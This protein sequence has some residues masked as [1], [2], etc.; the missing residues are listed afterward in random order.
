[1]KNIFVLLFILSTMV[2]AEE[3]LLTI[4]KEHHGHHGH[5]HQAHSQSPIGVMGAHL[6]DEGQWMF[7][8]RFKYMDMEGLRD[9][10]K[11]VSHLDNVGNP[12]AQPGR[13]MV[14]PRR[15]RMKMHMLSAMYG[16]TDKWTI[17]LMVPW[18]EK[19]M[20]H[21]A[22]PGNHFTTR[23]DGFGDIKVNSLYKLFGSEEFDLIFNLGVSL[24]TGNID[25][26]G[27]TPLAPNGV[28]LP[29][30]MQLGSGTLDISPGLTLVGH[31]ENW[32]WGLQT[33]ATLRFFRNSEGYNQGNSLLVNA[34]ASRK[35]TRNF[36]LSLRMEINSWEDF[37]GHDDTINNSQRIIPTADND[38]R[39]GSRLDVHLGCNYLVTEGLMA[40]HN[41]GVE[42][43]MP[44]YQYIDGPNLETDISVT[45][46]WQYRF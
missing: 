21:K 34:W 23:S 36:S 24:P 31:K 19:D 3:P 7:S 1:M 44:V 8:Y 4:D 5:D 38:L 13:F 15:M 28:K 2:K 16:V 9:G 26:K 35:L 45:L 18:L 6:H 33:I 10:D 29:Y 43:G 14:L 40:G 11:R 41:F 42:V 37:Q 30:P 17:A 25:E 22:L 46:G 20:S 32:G 39:G 27:N 12:N